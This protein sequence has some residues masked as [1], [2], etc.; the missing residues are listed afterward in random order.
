M[1]QRS[2][3]FLNEVISQGGFP[4]TR[5]TAYAWMKHDG[6]DARTCDAMAFGPRRQVAAAPMTLAEVLEC[7]GCAA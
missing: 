1:Q 6:F 4:M 5:A 7:V 3:S 2:N